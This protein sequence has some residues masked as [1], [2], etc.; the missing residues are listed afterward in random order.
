MPGRGCSR[1]NVRVARFPNLVTQ[2]HPTRNATML[3][4][5]VRA[6][7]HTKVWWRCP[8]GPDHEWCAQ[9]KSRI[10]P[11]ARGCPFCSG[12]RPSVTNSLAIVAPTL[13]AEWDAERNAALTPADVVAGSAR[14]CW[15]RCTAGHSWNAQVRLRVTGHACPFCA[16]QRV[17]TTNNIAAGYPEVA[18]EW[19]TAKNASGPPSEIVAGSRKKYWWRCARRHSWEATVASRTRLGAGC[20]HCAREQLRGRPR[21]RPART[22]EDREERLSELD[23][24]RGSA[25]LVTDPAALLAACDAGSVRTQSTRAAAKR[26]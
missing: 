9:V 11:R 24:I 1:S 23:G 14:K 16:G 6:G 12:H 13:V 25:A 8:R 5:D 7:S 17:S 4:A 19:D 20:P 2:W 3:P 21:N 10:G 18:A 22:R 26:G 15:W